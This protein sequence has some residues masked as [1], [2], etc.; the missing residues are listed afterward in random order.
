MKRLWQTC[1]VVV[2]IVVAATAQSTTTRSVYAIRGAKIYPVSG[3]VISDG[4]I[5]IRN[6]LIATI[7]A[8][9]QIPPEATVIEGMGLVVYPG[10][11]DSFT[12]AGLPATPVA[13]AAAAQQQGQQQQAQ[14]QP[15]PKNT[16]EA[17]FQTPLGLN[18]D[19]VLAQQVRPTGKDVETYRNLGITSALT[20][21]RDGVLTGQSV[22]INTGDSNIVVKTPVALHINPASVAGGYPST[23]MGALAVLRQAFSDADWYK[24]SWDKFN[25]NPRGI[26]RPPYDRVLD[27]MVPVLQG[28]LPS[29]IHADWNAQIKRAVALAEELMLKPIIAGGYEAGSLA[30]MLKS[31]DIPV[32]VS[33]NYA[34][35]KPRAGAT[36][37]AEFDEEETK[38]FLSNAALLQKAGV[39]FALQSGFAERPQLFFDNIRKAMDNGLTRDQ[40]L[41]A[42]TL[43]PAEI[44]GVGNA[45]GSLEPGKIANVVVATGEPFARDTRIRM[46]FVDGKLFEPPAT[47]TPRNT[48]ENRGEGRGAAPAETPAATSKK[49]VVKPG[50][51][52]TATPKEVLI[53]NA[54]ILTVSK[55]TI[56][57]GS[58]LVRDGKIAAV[59]AGI[60]ASA[61]AKIIDATGR[62]VMPGIIDA[63]SHLAIEG[64]GNESTSPV[65]PNVRIR[66]VIREDDVGIYRAV[67][68]GTTIVNVLHGS[69]NVIGGTNAVIKL[70]WGK[71]S[72]EMFF[73]APLGIKFALGENPKRANNTTQT[74]NNRR[75]PATRLGVEETLRESFNEARRYM[76]DWDAYEAARRRGE[77]PMPLRRDLKLET[78][79]D[80]LRGK[81][82]VHV[83]SY[84]APEIVMMLNI[85]DEF[86]F[87][88]TTLQH[89]L[90]GYKVAKEIK[91]HGA[92]ASTFA[93]FWAYK[94]EAWDAIP[95]NPTIMH[96]YGVNVSI[97]SD[98]DER[99]RRLYEEA[100]RAL[101][102]SN[103]ELTE[104]DALKFIT[105]N[106]AIQLGIDK[107]VGSI[108]V[109]KDADLV[110]FTGHPLSSYARVDMTLIDG[111]IYFDRELDLQAQ[112]R[113]AW[114][115]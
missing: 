23:L 12:D 76:K 77:D 82:L 48:T 5:V 37:A 58:V 14:Q 1:V 100:G 66:D 57:N 86:G 10:L 90:E 45:L 101:H 18:A 107:R 13:L 25:R 85:A 115:K 60:T 99:V 98:S 2:L 112:P 79:A 65:T 51:Y 40:A 97:N 111:Q 19:R 62:F 9:V 6:S 38:E 70:K 104:D 93:D 87:K 106:P 78:L 92:A 27:S 47:E 96:K 69:A 63:H 20:V 102:Y 7:G 108:E 29:I 46:V 110:I 103:G 21:S 33:V 34:R 55:G 59:G 91:A 30:A 95:E 109:G 52:I 8:N 49:P 81:I 68:G 28:Q 32:L 36:G 17:L 39:R 75:W 88:V 31:K 50:S 24:Q 42:T 54:T 44:L 64:G 80:V 16:Q 61:D 53:K 73:G 43:S 83:H 94:M 4:T 105:L 114:T 15:T 35:Q 72:E 11:I 84:V 113:E 3:E 74:A 22:L 71:P 41:H 56:K 89:V 26:E 67:A